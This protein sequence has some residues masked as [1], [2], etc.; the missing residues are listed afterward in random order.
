MVGHMNQ[1]HYMALRGVLGLTMPI[2]HPPGLMVALDSVCGPCGSHKCMIRTCATPG[3][4]PITGHHPGGP[5]A[6]P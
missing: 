4:R 3:T 1:G 2:R 6:W 5:M